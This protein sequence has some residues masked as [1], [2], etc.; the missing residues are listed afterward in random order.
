MET[1]SR[2]IDLQLE[3]KNFLVNVEK[4]IN[5]IAR[6]NCMVENQPSSPFI[7][8]K[9]LMENYLSPSDFELTLNLFSHSFV[10]RICA[11]AEQKGELSS[12]GI[13]LGGA[14]KIRPIDFLEYV[15]KR[16]KRGSQ[17]ALRILQNPRALQMINELLE[18][19][20]KNDKT[21]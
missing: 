4:K 18:S 10:T 2:F 14:W 7:S 13:K 9:E 21:C 1:L 6:E 15:V 11:E 3:I 17:K 5:R 16:K 20:R 8:E 12:F 19:R